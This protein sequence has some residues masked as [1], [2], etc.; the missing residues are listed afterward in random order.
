MERDQTYVIPL[1]YG[2]RKT[3]REFVRAILNRYDPDTLVGAI[4][5]VN[6]NPYSLQSF[7]CLNFWK[8]TEDFEQWLSSNYPTKSRDFRF[9]FSEMVNAIFDR[10]FNI[11]GFGGDSMLEFQMSDE[12]ND[13]YLFPSRDV[14][15]ETFGKPNTA[16]TL[17]VFLSHSSRDKSIVDSIF[18]E[19]HKNNIRA[20]YDRYEIRPGDSITDSIN[21]GLQKCQLGL[22]FFSKN[23][24][25]PRSGWP[26]NEANYFFTQRMKDK[27]KKFIVVNIDLEVSEMPP[28][29]QDYLFIDIRSSNAI[30]QIVDA[31]VREQQSL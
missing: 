2:D 9:L 4:L 1:D 17:S 21:E 12:P 14:M 20:W 8:D 10:G 11:I 16:N 30:Q 18:P 22:L 15:N 31:I 27:K 28:L 3:E 24:L 26:M 25:D 23:F 7:L 6:N 19:L 29:M 13:I 5:C